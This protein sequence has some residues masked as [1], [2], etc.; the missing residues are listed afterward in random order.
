MAGSISGLNT[1]AS[2]SGPIPLVQ[3]DNNVSTLTTALNTLQNFDNY[4]VDSGSVNSIVVTVLSPQVIV[5][6]AGLLIQI[7]VAN[8]NTGAVTINVNGLGSVNVVS[9]AGL[10]LAASVLTAGGVYQFQHDGTNFQL[11][12]PNYSITKV[13]SYFVK[14]SNTA[15]ASTTALSNDPDL[16]Y[17]IPAAG[18]YKI[19]LYLYLSYLLATIPAGGY[20]FNLNYSGSF[21]SGVG[22]STFVNEGG[23]TSQGQGLLIQSSAATSAFSYVPSLSPNT[24]SSNFTITGVLVATGAGTLG[25][26]WAQGVSNAT[27]TTLYAGSNMSVVKLT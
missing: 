25:L 27:A 12:T 23:N 14:T 21:T 22:G 13:P 9:P 20:S 15:R 7:K 11:Q 10:A 19:E 4:Y 3:L 17:A 6:G 1:F 16:I 24:Y 18:T 5:Y 26:S 8:T 2:Q